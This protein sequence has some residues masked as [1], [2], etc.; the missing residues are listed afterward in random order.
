MDSCFP[1][2]QLLPVAPKLG[3]SAS[4]IAATD[5]LLQPRGTADSTV[6]AVTAPTPTGSRSWKLEL[7]AG[8][9]KPRR[10]G[11]ALSTV[12]VRATFKWRV[13]VLFVTSDT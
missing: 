2:Q 5:T 11:L 8:A 3:T 12:Q 13:C 1:V 10:P 9:E 4:S 7:K 6:A